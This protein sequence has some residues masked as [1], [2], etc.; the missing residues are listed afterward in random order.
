MNSMAFQ[1]LVHPLG[2][3]MQDVTTVVSKLTQELVDFPEDKTLEQPLGQDRCFTGYPSDNQS[4][5]VF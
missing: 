2:V 1:T 5:T 4:A 3:S